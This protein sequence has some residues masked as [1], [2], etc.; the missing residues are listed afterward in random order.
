MGESTQRNPANQSRAAF[1]LVEIM[2]VVVVIGIL[3]SLALPAFTGAKRKSE[4]SKLV[5][6][7]QSF[8]SAFQQYALEVGNWPA[9]EV[10][11][12][13]P[14]ELDG[15]VSR[16]LFE[17]TTVDGS[18]WDWQGPGGATGTTYGLAL[19]GGSLEDERMEEVDALLDD[20][21]LGTGTFQLIG[22][23]YTL[24]FEG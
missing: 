6:D 23:H 1:T 14:S 8:R 16:T 12:V 10:V 24:I 15:Y 9:N 11:G 3:A 18:R 2:V 22:S 20:G 17:K 7:F 13:M 19:L 21:D 5:A 4:N